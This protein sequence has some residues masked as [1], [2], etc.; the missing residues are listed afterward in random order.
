MNNFNLEQFLKGK[1]V[2]IVGPAESTMNNKDGIFI[3][4]FDVIVRVNRG[5]EPTELYK[6][7][8]GSRT[9]LLY[10]CLYEHPDNGGIIDLD[11]FKWNKNMSIVDKEEY[12]KFE[13]ELKCRPNCGTVAIWD[14]LQYD[15]KELYITG[16]TFYL[17]NFMQGYKDHVD[18]KKFKNKCFKSERHNQKNLWNF[19]KKQKKKDNRIKTDKYLEKILSLDN[20]NNNEETIKFVFN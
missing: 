16:F 10:N 4:S 14:L 3:D 12:L 9:D 2:I 1:R 5:I 8:I 15:I 17:D 7:Y 20:L 11:Y 19:L 6:E 18:K 13:K